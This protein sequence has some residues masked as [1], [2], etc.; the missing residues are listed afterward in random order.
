VQPGSLLLDARTWLGVHGT[1]SLGASGEKLVTEP[2]RVGPGAISVG[3]SV[4]AYRYGGS[5]AGL[6]EWNVTVVP[7][8]GFANYHIALDDRRFDPYVGLGLGYAVVQASARTAGGGVA[9]VGRASGVYSFGHLGA[10][11][12]VSPRLAVQA[13]TGWGLGS[14]SVGVSWKR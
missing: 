2:G 9:S 8:G 11:Y 4:D 10:R 13:Q 1:L 3:A 7:V 12:F 14:L 6:G 5:Y